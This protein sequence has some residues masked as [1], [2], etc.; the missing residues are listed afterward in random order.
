M[1][2]DRRFGMVGRGGGGGRWWRGR[3]RGRWPS[4]DA[5]PSKPIKARK[6]LNAIGIL[7]FVGIGGEG[8]I[9]GR[10]VCNRSL[11][12]SQ[13]RSRW[14]HRR[15]LWGPLRRRRRRCWRQYVARRVEKSAGPRQKPNHPPTRPAMN[16]LFCPKNPRCEIRTLHAAR[17]GKPRKP[18]KPRL[19]HFPGDSPLAYT[20]WYGTM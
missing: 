17:S 9:S 10:F 4:L 8:G 6:L 5:H 18:R 1:V 3:H 11:G 2:G 19:F 7:A 14:G 16:L 13:S 20:M 15:D 12:H